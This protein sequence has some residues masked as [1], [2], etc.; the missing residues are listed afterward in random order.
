VGKTTL[1]IETARHLAPD[2]ADGACLVELASVSEPSETATATARALGITV[3]DQ[4]LPDAALKRVLPPCNML[5]VLDN[6]EH[7]LAGATLVGELLAACPRITIL[8]TSREPTRL[9]AERVYPVSPLAIPPPI[10]GQSPGEMERYGSVAMFRD[11]AQARDP[12]FMLDGTTAPDVADVCRRLDGLPL[13]LELAAARIGPLSVSELSGRLGDALE[14]LTTAARDAPARQRTLRTTI[15]WSYDLLGSQ[16]RA[17]LRRLAV[18]AGSFDLE[19]AESVC[20]GGGVAHADVAELLWTL[21]DSSLVVRE[22]AAGLSRYSLLSTVRAYAASRSGAEEHAAA[23]RRLA[24]RYQDLVGPH[25][26]GMR[27]WVELVALELDNLRQVAAELPDHATA[28]ALAW[29]IGR[30]HEL[31]DAFRVGIEELTRWTRRLP[32]EG[33]NRVALLTLLANLHLSVGELDRA[34][35]LVAEAAELRAMAGPAEWDAAGVARTRSE[36][37]LRRGDAAAAAQEARAALAEPQS[38]QSR[39]LLHNVLGGALVALGDVEGAA[40]AFEQEVACAKAAGM[41]TFLAT[42]YGNLA[43]AQLRLGNE[44]A[45]AGNQAASLELARADGKPLIIAFAMNIAARLAAARQ[46]PHEAVVLQTAADRAFAET[47]FAFTQ[48]DLEV[49]AALLRGARGDLGEVR[50]EQAV[51]DARNLDPDAAADLAA[52]VLQ[53]VRLQAAEQDASG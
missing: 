6:F 7:L 3:R 14:I 36:L 40:A 10:I 21:V 28:Q 26:A 4:E 23:L 46:Q 50:F 51:T 44:S 15:D 33:P 35:V 5:L 12:T 11:R 9:G 29:S 8:V 25:R 19:T 42:S 39:A 47:S 34:G 32:S 27:R 18:F 13:A 24:D 20:V 37:A 22:P 16:A 2:F 31:N 41:E 43:E 45:A 30:Y 38:E 49:R 53:A 1:A 17:V 48:Q 52:S